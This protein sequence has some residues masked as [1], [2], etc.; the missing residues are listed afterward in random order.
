MFLWGHLQPGH[1]ENGCLETGCCVCRPNFSQKPVGYSCT[2]VSQAVRAN[3]NVEQE[4]QYLLYKDLDP[5]NRLNVH[6][7]HL[8]PASSGTAAA[9]SEHRS[10]NRGSRRPPP[11]QLP[12]CQKENPWP[13]KEG[14]LAIGSTKGKLCKLG[15]PV[16][17]L[18]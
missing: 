12:P 1:G 10:A 3:K 15:P 2:M 4:L 11:G 9:R 8:F 17:R 16:E 18:G 7:G 14:P 5:L 13:K 6:L